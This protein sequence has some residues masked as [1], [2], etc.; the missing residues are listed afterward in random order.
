VG[1]GGYTRSPIN[2]PPGDAEYRMNKGKEERDK[3]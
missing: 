3:K 2:P 1:P